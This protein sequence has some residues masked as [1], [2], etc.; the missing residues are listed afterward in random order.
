VSSERALVRQGENAAVI[1]AKVD[2]T[3]SHL[4]EVELVPGG[5]NRARHN[6]VPV[7]PREIVGILRSV[8]FSPEDI[9]VVKSEPSL[10]RRF[11]DDVISQMKPAYVGVRRDFDRVLLQRSAALK[12]VA[13]G[14]DPGML[15]VWD[16]SL[17]SLGAQV[18]AHRRALTSALAEVFTDKYGKVADDSKAA[19][20]SYS[21]GSAGKISDIEVTGR[22]Q[23]GYFLSLDED[24]SRLKSDYID[25][26]R[27]RKP[28]ELRRRQNLIGPHRDDIKIEIGGLPLKGFASHGES[29]SAALALRL[30]QSEV[31]STEMGPPIL[32]LDDVFAELD[33]QR[34]TALSAEISSFEQVFV[35]SAVD[36]DVPSNASVVIRIDWDS[37]RG[38]EIVK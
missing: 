6:R 24:V 19:V 16:E 4:I 18:A 38:S 12:D 28:E 27:E 3:R 1:R 30:S 14:R 35:T 37:E 29:W 36:T 33:P 20:L 26:I 13:Y 11:L 5:A 2:G 8:T 31:M 15:E 7:A 17:A 10:R 25:M 9:Q 22:I 32:I 21:Q 34:R 23:E